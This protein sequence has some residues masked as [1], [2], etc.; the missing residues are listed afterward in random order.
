MDEVLARVRADY[1]RDPAREWDRLESGAQNRLE[2]LVTTTALERHL[3]PLDRPRRVLAAGGGP[4]RYTL[5]LAG[6]GYRVT[7]R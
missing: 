4:G 1:D 2:Y 5:L 6:R 3:P 7:L